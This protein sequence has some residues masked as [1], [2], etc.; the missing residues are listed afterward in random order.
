M[1]RKKIWR[2]NDVRLFQFL[3]AKGRLDLLLFL[4]WGD[5]NVIY[6]RFFK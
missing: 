4:E 1:V 2:E 6:E 3:P 5:F